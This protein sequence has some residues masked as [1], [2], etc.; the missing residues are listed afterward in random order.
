MLG[1]VAAENVLRRSRQATGA[2]GA[3]VGSSFGLDDQITT[4]LPHCGQAL[5][6]DSPRVLV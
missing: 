3:V 5:I 4:S 2:A 6:G 1:A